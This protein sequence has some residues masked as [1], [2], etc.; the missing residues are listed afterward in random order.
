VSEELVATERTAM[1][2]AE[3]FAALKAAWSTLLPTSP[4]RSSVLVLLAQWSVET[5]GG[6][7]SNN[8]NLAG[9]KHVPGDGHNYAR[10]LTREV[11]GGKSVE[12]DQDF[13]AYASLDDAAL[14]YVRLLRNRFGYAW[15]AIESADLDDFAHR[16]RSRGYYTAD[17]H[18]YAAALH[19][20]Y[21]QLDRVIP[22]DPEETDPATPLA[23][24]GRPAYVAPDPE[25]E[26][27]PPDAEG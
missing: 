25:P 17:E 20:R 4:V 27:P 2:P 24:S 19:T 15:P 1:T 6:G 12:L 14:D 16:L 23:L 18:D 10:Y 7:Q 26:D 22:P 13:R 8:W 21:A 5:G 11:L 3:V 9:I